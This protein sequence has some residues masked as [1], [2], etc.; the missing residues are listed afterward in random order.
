MDDLAFARAL[1]RL[2]EGSDPF[3]VATIVRTVG[4][5][6]GKPGF[7]ILISHE[8][9]VLAGSLGGG[10]PEGPVVA[11]ARR[12]MKEARPSMLRVYLED[13]DAAVQATVEAADEEVHLETD[14]G[15]VLEVYVEPY[16]P[17]ER[18]VIVGQG[19]RDAVEDHLVQLGRLLGFHL[20]VVDHA[21][22]LSAEPDELL[23]DL[24]F[25][26]QAFPWRPSD[27]VVLL[28][29]SER[30]V[31]MLADL[32]G[33]DLRY[34][35]LL[36]SRSR[37]RKTLEALRKQGVSK[38]FLDRVRTPVGLDIGARSPE[39]IALSIL[40][41]IVAVRRGKELRGEDGAARKSATKRPTEA[42]ERG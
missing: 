29:K 20:V 6:L 39:E 13:A 16:I 33:F 17:K 4:S 1:G 27:A 34:V 9:E 10:C 24:E 5:S 21:P 36:A 12:A 30:S 31:G 32:S 37:G 19:G 22:S 8:G 38:E 40:A 25:D 23:D 2:G 7:K 14:C 41:E 28:V 26:V 15:G 3:A 42:H 35:G 18:L 11:A